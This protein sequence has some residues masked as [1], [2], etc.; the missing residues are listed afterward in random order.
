[1]TKNEKKFAVI[2]PITQVKYKKFCRNIYR[3]YHRQFIIVKN[4]DVFID[5]HLLMKILI[6]NLEKF[7]NKSYVRHVKYTKMDFIN[8]II[9]IIN[10]NTYWRRYKKPINGPDGN[11]LNKKHNQY[12]RL[13]LYE[14]LYYII[15]NIYFE[16]SKY[17]KLKH[18]SIDTTFIRNLYGT[19]LIQRNTQNK[20][21]NGIKVSTINDVNGVVTSLAIGKGAMN[22]SKIAIE[23]L[24]F[25]FV[26]ANTKQVKNNKKYSQNMYADS[27]YDSEELYKILRGKGYRPITDVNIRNTKNETKLKELKKRKRKYLKVASKRSSIERSYGWLHKYPKLDRCVEKKLNSYIGLLLLGLSIT[28]SR[29]IT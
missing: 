2:R 20:S 25:S 10:N 7:K 11:Y 4:K 29:K 26:E 14:Y 1:M 13:G 3:R 19:E 28:V 23:Q 17:A 24:K 18:Q 9:D 16:K 12:C 5:I 6:D 22:D 21:K 15:V 8:G 27:Q